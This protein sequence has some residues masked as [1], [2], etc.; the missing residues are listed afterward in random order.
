MATGCLSPAVPVGGTSPQCHS[1]QLCGPDARTDSSEAPDRPRRCLNPLCHLSAAPARAT[2]RVPHLIMP[3]LA[4][5]LMLQVW[6]G[7]TSS[8]TTIL[9]R[10]RWVLRTAVGALGA[11]AGLVITCRRT[12]S[13]YNSTSASATLWFTRQPGRSGADK[14]G[15]ALNDTVQPGRFCWQRPISA[16]FGSTFIHLPVVFRLFGLTGFILFRLGRCWLALDQQNS[17]AEPALAD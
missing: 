17:V 6:A 7:A 2:L 3:V 11:G 15:R 14:S 4:S 10:P 16:V 8:A 9:V 12:Q 13:T 5:L 1:G